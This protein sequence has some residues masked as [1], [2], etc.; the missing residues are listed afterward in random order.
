MRDVRWSK[1]RGG[2]QSIA[3]LEKAIDIQQAHGLAVDAQLGP[4]ENLEELVE[5]AQPSWEGDEGV[6]D[7]CHA[8]LAFV[9]GLDDVEALHAFVRKL[10][11]FEEF[12]DDAYAAPTMRE[13][14]VGNLAHQ[15]HVAAAIDELGA[16][17]GEQLAQLSCSEGEGGVVAAGGTAEDADAGEGSGGVVG[18]GRGE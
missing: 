6:G 3:G 17:V 13:D 16:L 18:H 8:H 4:R 15:P 10:A 9:H 1:L 7:G 14:A 2:L 12:G 11:S 5:R